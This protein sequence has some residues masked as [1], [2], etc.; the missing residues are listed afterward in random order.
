MFQCLQ[1]HHHVIIEVVSQ[2]LLHHLLEWPLTP[3]KQTDHYSCNNG[4]ILLSAVFES[5]TVKRIFLPRNYEFSDTKHVLCNLPAVLIF[6]V[7]HLYFLEWTKHCNEFLTVFDY[8]YKMILSCCTWLC[9]FFFEGI[10]KL[11]IL[12][13][14]RVVGWYMT[15]ILK[16]RNRC[17]ED[18]QIKPFKPQTMA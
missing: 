14:Y 7:L 8:S 6:I 12:I 5:F 4:T 16:I 1:F 11:Y 10:R 13:G 18:H 17:H 3:Q 15:Q 9:V 2:G